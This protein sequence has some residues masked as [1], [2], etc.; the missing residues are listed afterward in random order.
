[1]SDLNM[2]HFQELR[3][4]INHRLEELGTPHRTLQLDE[5]P[6]L[7]GALGAVPSDVMFIC[8]NP[9]IAGVRQANT[10]TIDGGAPDIEAQWWGGRKNPAAKRFRPVLTE[11][12]LKTNGPDQ[13]G[14]WNCYITNVV[15]EANLAGADQQMK[16]TA[17]RQEQARDW[18]DI[19][20]WEIEQVRPKRVFCVGS[21]AHAMVSFLRRERL[22]PFFTPHKIGHYSARGS[23]EDVIQQMLLPL[24]AV[25]GKQG[26]RDA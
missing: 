10:D 11:M 22:L 21:A 6:W 9:S 4:R 17:E 20:K 16:S 13:R 12:G 25:F 26:A 18:A 3:A 23:D 14:G 19:L 5:Y 24:Q 2:S 8:E 1:M 15:K 7:Y